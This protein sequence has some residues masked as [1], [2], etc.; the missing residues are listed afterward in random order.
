MSLKKHVVR[1]CH[2]LEV[3]QQLNAQCFSGD[4]KSNSSKDSCLI[5]LPVTKQVHS[6]TGIQGL[7][8]KIMV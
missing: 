3:Y 1:A 7:K 2:I 6:S 5:Y 4:T 8:H